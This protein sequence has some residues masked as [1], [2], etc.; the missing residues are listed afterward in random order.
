M[1]QACVP[2]F[3]PSRPSVILDASSRVLAFNACRIGG[4]EHASSPGPPQPHARK[5]IA[6][7]RS[8]VRQAHR[9]VESYNSRL[10]FN[11]QEMI[12]FLRR[13][14]RR[15]PVAVSLDT[16]NQPFLQAS[17]PATHTIRHASQV[18]G[19]G[20]DATVEQSASTNR[21]TRGLAGDY[22][23]GVGRLPPRGALLDRSATMSSSFKVCRA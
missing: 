2:T 15:S 16:L 1:P 8:R 4:G 7:T 18:G 21:Q 13:S 19:H 17:A 20:V 22:A 6:D 23:D 3:L 10:R 11:V 14:K 5:P 12:C 9:D